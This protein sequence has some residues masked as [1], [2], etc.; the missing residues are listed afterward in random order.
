MT[1]E[2][3]LNKGFKKINDNFGKIIKI[4]YYTQSYDDVYDEPEFLTYSGAIWT[5]GIILPINRLEGTK[6]YILQQQ[7]RLQDNDLHLFISGNIS[8]GASGTPIKIQAGSP[9]TNSEA[10][11]TINT[12]IQEYNVRNIS[13][14]KKAYIRKLP[15]GSFTGEVAYGG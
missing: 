1:T 13:I 5:S 12:G 11:T 2:D 6:D 9:E 10:F 4:T 3:I 7:G 8:L 14:F 15:T